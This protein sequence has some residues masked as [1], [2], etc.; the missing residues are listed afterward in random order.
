MA[1]IDGSVGSY[2]AIDGILFKSYAMVGE[3]R[4]RKRAVEGLRGVG[5]QD[6]RECAASARRL[7]SR[8][9]TLKCATLTP[10]IVEC[11]DVFLIGIDGIRLGLA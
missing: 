10:P 3:D 2:A 11:Q 5:G 1:E 6:G 8:K 7:A 9:I 4:R